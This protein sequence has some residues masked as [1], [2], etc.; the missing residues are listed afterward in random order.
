MFQIICYGVRPNEV[1]I[2]KKFNRYGYALTLE[3][4]LLTHENIETAK[5][6]DAVLLRGNCVA[7]RDNLAKM[8]EYGIRYV[9]SRTVG[10]NHIDLEAAKEF[11]QIIARVPGYSPRSV[12]ELALT[13]GMTL[14][15]N[16]QYTADRTHRG[17]FRITPRMFSRE[18]RNC[19][20]GIVGVGR[21]GLTEAK[22]YR[23]LGARVLGYDFYPSK[24]AQKIVEFTDL[25][26]LARVSDIVS[27]HVPYFKGENDDFI[28]AEFIEKMKDDAIL[29]NTARGEL[30]DLTAVADALEEDRLYGFATD[31]IP[32]ERDTY[33]QR[34][35]AVDDIPD[36]AVVR[37]VSC[38][39]RALF[40]PHVGSNTDEAVENMV[41]TSLD[42]FNEIL[43]T[44][45]CTN[46]LR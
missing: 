39:P 41:E 1:E 4:A 37:L 17:D 21:I 22:L 10:Y 27:I 38:Y 25:D 45:T 5:G 23:G 34:F 42:N 20:V 19:T 2:F 35:D 15:R 32:N 12:A 24:A 31:V 11:G 18:I 8:K 36:P 14:L 6:H 28:N 29:V 44:G 33:F 30:V 16:V 9:F 43:T 7:D 40:T 3:E 13:L 46:L 26:T